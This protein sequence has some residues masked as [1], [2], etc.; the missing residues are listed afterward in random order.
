M[1]ISILKIKLRC[2]I[3]VKLKQTDN[4]HL[5]CKYEKLSYLND[6]SFY[7]KAMPLFANFFFL[8]Y[9][10]IRCRSKTH[11]YLLR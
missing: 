10:Y 3:N 7:H 1:H 6:P 11:F 8:L 9:L 2:K 4:E 5:Y